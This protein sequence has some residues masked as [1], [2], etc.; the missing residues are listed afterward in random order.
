LPLP[1]RGVVNTLGAL[2]ATADSLQA[3]GTQLN[4]SLNGCMCGHTGG[5]SSRFTTHPVTHPACLGEHAWLAQ[6]VAH[7]LASILVR[8]GGVAGLWAGAGPA[9]QRAALVNLGEL[10]TYDTVGWW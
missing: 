4:Q 1:M 3:H 9:I 10:A 8:E 7:A 6:G 5:S 2:E